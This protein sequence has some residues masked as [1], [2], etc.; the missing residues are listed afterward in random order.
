MNNLLSI[1]KAG[2]EKDIE[3]PMAEKKADKCRCVKTQHLGDI[4]LSKERLAVR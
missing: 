2:L 4:N 3:T 1:L